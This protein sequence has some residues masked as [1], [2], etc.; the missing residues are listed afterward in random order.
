VEIFFFEVRV[1]SVGA[2]ARER[3]CQEP[4]AKSRAAFAPYYL[5]APFHPF[6]HEFSE[7]YFFLVFSYLELDA[8][9]T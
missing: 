1:W 2:L 6:G 3:I 7:I 4:K 5:H 9:M 8:S